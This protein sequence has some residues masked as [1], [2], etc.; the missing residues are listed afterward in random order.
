MS[1]SDVDGNELPFQL[2]PA[3]NH[4][5]QTLGFSET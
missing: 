2:L 3:E 5:A 4:R 1:H